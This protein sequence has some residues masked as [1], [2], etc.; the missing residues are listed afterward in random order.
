MD[1]H[2]ANRPKSEEKSVQMAEVHLYRIYFLQNPCF[3]RHTNM[4]QKKK[5]WPKMYLYAEQ[6]V[7][8]VI[9]IVF[10]DLLFP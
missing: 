5:N 6:Y 10:T 2:T 4:C 8:N 3:K 1:T 9:L 7:Y